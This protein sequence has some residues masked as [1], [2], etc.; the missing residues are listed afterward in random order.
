V[1]PTAPLVRAIREAAADERVRAA[2]GERLPS[3]INGDRLNEAALPWLLGLAS[4]GSLL[5]AV[6]C[7]SAS[8]FQ[9]ADQHRRAAARV[10]SEEKRSASGANDVASSETDSDTGLGK[11]CSFG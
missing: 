11:E 9:L 1:T 6:G 5:E 2:I 4:L 10:R 7:E 3:T 8:T